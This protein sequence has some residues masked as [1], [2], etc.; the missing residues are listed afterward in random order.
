MQQQPV[1]QHTLT[2][3]KPFGTPGVQGGLTEEIQP[4]RRL[5]MERGESSTS[6]VESFAP[7]PVMEDSDQS[8]KEMIINTRRDQCANRRR[9]R[10]KTAVIAERFVGYDSSEYKQPQYVLY[11]PESANMGSVD[12]PEGTTIQPYS[13][14]SSKDGEELEN[15]ARYLHAHLK[16]WYLPDAD[17]TEVHQRLRNQP[18]GSFIVCKSNVHSDSYKLYFKHRSIQ[19]IAIDRVYDRFVLRDIPRCHGYTSLL[20]LIATHCYHAHIL[21]CKLQIPSRQLLSM[22]GSPFSLSMTDMFET[23]RTDKQSSFREV[24]AFRFSR[25]PRTDHNARELQFDQGTR[26]TPAT[27]RR[28]GLGNCTRW[29]KSVSS[30]IPQGAAC[31]LFYFGHFDVGAYTASQA[32][33]VCVDHLLDERMHTLHPIPI[34]FRVNEN[35]ITMADFEQRFFTRRHIPATFVR[36]IGLDPLRRV[37]HAKALY[38]EAPK[39][40][41][42]FGFTSRNPSLAQG[43]NQCHLLSE[44][45]QTEQAETIC[46]FTQRY[47]NLCVV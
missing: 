20:Q 47:F 41:R 21:P 24:A 16:H 1:S 12:H 34:E 11:S 18:P 23:K 33:R 31:K 32:I 5:Q 40:S 4:H 39:E 2:S 6:S 22:I 14:K 7:D 3:C 44:Y 15:I 38:S 36:H 10:E 9:R 45:E 27:R 8:L 35:G 25:S 43:K 28:T 30:L 26:Q 29:H 19:C 42:I 46:A 17:I 37:W 13:P